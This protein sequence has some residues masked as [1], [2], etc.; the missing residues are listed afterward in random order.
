MC[1][2]R[3]IV[4]LHPLPRS[5]RTGAACQPAVLSPRMAGFSF[6]DP[7]RAPSSGTL[8]SC[9]A[10]PRDRLLLVPLVPIWPS[11]RSKLAAP[12]AAH[13]RAKRRHRNIVTQSVHVDDCL[14]AAIHI[15]AINKQ[16]PH[17]IGAHVA[18]GHGDGQSLKL[19]EHSAPYEFSSS[20]AGGALAPV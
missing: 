17:A 1:C 11:V 8:A 19:L 3:V 5:P 15:R 16:R 4:R 18:E 7:L 10:R 9:A 2:R 12:L 20:K 14:V 13:S 6:F